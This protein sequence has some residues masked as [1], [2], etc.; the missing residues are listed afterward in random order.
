MNDSFLS[1]SVMNDPYMTS[2][3]DSSASGSGS[4]GGSLRRP[5]REDGAP[6]P[7]VQQVARERVR[8]AA[9]GRDAVAAPRRRLA[10]TTWPERERHLV[11]AYECVAGLHNALGLTERVN[12]RTRPFFDRPFQV[13]DAGRFVTPLLAG[14]PWT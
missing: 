7:A 9:R 4:P 12:P 10:A 3:R 13:I 2:R 11:A 14:T 5:V 8:A 6:V 1:S